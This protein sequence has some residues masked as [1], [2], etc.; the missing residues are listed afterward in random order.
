MEFKSKNPLLTGK[1]YE[2]SAQNVYTVDGS[3]IIDYNNTMTV[4]GT[5]NKTFILFGLLLVGA[6]VPFYMAVI[7]INP[8]MPGIISLFIALGMV[9][10]CTVSPKNAAYLAPAYALFEGV[11]IGAVSLFFEVMYPGIVIKAVAGTLVTFGVCLALYRFGVVKVTE[12]FRSVV[13]AA[14]A[15]IG[16]YYLISMLFFWIGGVSFFHHDNSLMSIGFS[17]AV[18]VIAALSLI[19][20]FDMIEKGAKQ[21]M[22]KHMEWFS[23]MGL[24]V[25]LVWL[26]LEFLRLL[27]KLQS[28]N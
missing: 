6:I 28:R 13:I 25:T 21:R 2:K 24:I 20:D 10:A 27:S 18:I 1:S 17:I 7:G 4:K 9:I 11:F 22:P 23:G 19:L 8:M 12:Q 16:T 14:T 3:N 26:Y 5:I 15:A